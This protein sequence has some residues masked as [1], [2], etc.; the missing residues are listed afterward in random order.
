MLCVYSMHDKF[1]QQTRNWTSGKY[2]YIIIIIIR[3]GANQKR[4]TAPV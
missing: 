3:G 4:V 2:K 1:K